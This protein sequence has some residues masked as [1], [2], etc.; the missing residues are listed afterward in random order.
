MV[1]P[2]KVDQTRDKVYE[3][4]DTLTDETAQALFEEPFM[5][6]LDDLDAKARE[7]IF[8]TAKAEVDSLMTGKISWPGVFNTYAEI[9]SLVELIRTEATPEPE[10][11]LSDLALEVFSAQ[12]RIATLFYVLRKNKD[13]SEN[14]GRIVIEAAFPLAVRGLSLEAKK[15]IF[16]YVYER[17]SGL[18][19]GQVAEDYSSIIEL[20]ARIK[21]NSTMA[22]SN[23]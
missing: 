2:K 15:A 16:S 12:N 11:S 22:E 14:Q 10:S 21:P 6:T 3:Q 5:A 8:L 4:I 19:W 18:G 9:A 1:T 20:V 17:S 23:E 7:E 13:L